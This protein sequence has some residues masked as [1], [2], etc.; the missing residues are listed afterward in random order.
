[1]LRP[2]ALGAR[3]PYRGERAH[4]QRQRLWETRPITPSG[5]LRLNRDPSYAV[6]LIDALFSRV[7]RPNR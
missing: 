2:R 5:D 6:Y 1:M 4:K 7:L 3:Q